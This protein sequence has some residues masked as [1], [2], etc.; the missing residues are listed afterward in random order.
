M[1]DTVAEL[2]GS[3]CSDRASAAPTLASYA[4]VSGNATT[5]EGSMPLPDLTTANSHYD[6]T[7][8]SNDSAPQTLKDFLDF[9][10]VDAHIPQRSDDD[11]AASIYAP[12]ARPLLRR[13]TFLLPSTS[14]A[15]GQHLISASTRCLSRTDSASHHDRP[16]Q[17][18]Q[19]RIPRL[20]HQ[21]S[22]PRQGQGIGGGNPRSRRKLLY[23][24]FTPS[25]GKTQENIEGQP[26]ALNRAD[27]SQFPIPDFARSSSYAVSTGSPPRNSTLESSPNRKRRS[28]G[29]SPSQMPSVPL[30]FAQRD[31]RIVGAQRVERTSASYTFLP[32]DVSSLV[33]KRLSSESNEDYATAA[34]VAG[35]EAGFA[36]GDAFL[37]S[38]GEETGL[39]SGL[40]RAFNEGSH[41]H[42]ADNV[43]GSGLGRAYR[44]STP[45]SP[46]PKKILVQHKAFR[47][48]SRQ[49]RSVQGDLESMLGD[50]QSMPGSSGRK[51]RPSRKLS[52]ADRV[53]K[54]ALLPGIFDSEEEEEQV[55]SSKGG[56]AL[57]ARKRRLFRSPRIGPKTSEA[58][59]H[60][61]PSTCASSETDKAPSS[62]YK[63]KRLKLRHTG[64]GS[65]QLQTPI[66]SNTAAEILCNLQHIISNESATPQQHL[67][68][69]SARSLRAQ[70]RAQAVQKSL[71]TTE[72]EA[73]PREAGR[74]QS[75]RAAF[76]DD[77]SGDTDDA[78]LVEVTKQTDAFESASARKIEEVAVDQANDEHTS[79][80][81]CNAQQRVFPRHVDKQTARFPGF[82]Q[83]YAVPSQ[84]P[85]E[86][87]QKVFPQGAKDPSLSPALQVVANRG[88]FKFSGDPNV[89]LPDPFDLYIP[90]FTRGRGMKKEALCPIC[91]DAS[92]I[93]RGHASANWYQTKVSAYNYHLQISHG[94][95]SATGQ[96]MDPPV[97]FKS[98]ERSG[99]AVAAGERKTILQGECHAC[100]KWI[101]LESV[102]D[103]E[104]KIPEIYWRKHAAKCHKKRP[105]NGTSGVFVE[106]EFYFRVKAAYEAD[107]QK[108]C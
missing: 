42:W 4:D 68:T 30:A 83:R 16:T 82:Y 46:S 44:Y 56:Q 77:A 6:G 102:K 91:Y 71:L 48:V 98:I 28:G 15:R 62:S 12:D 38:S 97:R 24:G 74:R 85:E 89:S 95:M 34:S 2:D 84:L 23:S 88:F 29:P 9:M 59:A 75:S 7:E 96:P 72:T 63:S 93:G 65:S 78:G 105:M 101:A 18:A 27:S 11:G 33:D 64:E 19:D 3:G 69:L 73:I 87:Q 54:R 106:D 13:D 99:G 17:V 10:G 26:C 5:I 36:H 47:L 94:I 103:V 53:V 80:K 43:I 45:P 8:T 60:L 79:G 37:D 61:M 76:E 49:Q 52:T 107:S 51:S 50:G 40:R 1:A 22:T 35:S 108:Q 70:Q 20:F 66:S 81:S 57:S 100:G 86:I 25:P 90:R 31:P 21:F 104:V 92:P 41:G 55:A 14:S 32:S 67:L 39:T 58:L